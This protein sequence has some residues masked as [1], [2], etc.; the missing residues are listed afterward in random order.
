[1]AT[2]VERL[3]KQAME[4]PSESRAQLADLLV[5]SLDAQELGHIDRLWIA[6]AK[7]RRDEVR[8]GRV[9]TIP[10]DEALQKVRDIV[11]L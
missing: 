10:G 11:R 3:A 5:E 4:L 8:S 9:E 6:T 2:K 1:M 7:L